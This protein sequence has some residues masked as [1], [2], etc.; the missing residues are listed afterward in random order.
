MD[1]WELTHQAHVRVNME[2]YKE[3]VESVKM[4]L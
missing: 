3:M 1:L 4:K 2:L